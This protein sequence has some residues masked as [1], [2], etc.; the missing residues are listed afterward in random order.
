M[1]KSHEVEMTKLELDLKVWQLMKLNKG[2]FQYHG[3]LAE[4]YPW[5]PG[6]EVSFAVAIV[7]QKVW[8]YEDLVL[9]SSIRVQ[10]ILQFH[11]ARS[12]L[13][14]ANIAALFNLFQPAC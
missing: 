3:L 4:T 8:I 7:R 14:Q 6:Q 12:F 9:L 5:W 1:V 2:P 13:A 11:W 10:F